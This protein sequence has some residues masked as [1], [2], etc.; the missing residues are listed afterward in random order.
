MEYSFGST[1]HGAGRMLS[2]KAAMRQ[3][4]GRDLTQEL[5][6]QGVIVRA[7]SKETLAEEAPYAY[8]EISAVV[9]VAAGAQLSIKVARLKPIGVIK[10]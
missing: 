2:R 10:G 9:D 4:K 7:Q 1:C 6:E 3:S 5:K 8:K